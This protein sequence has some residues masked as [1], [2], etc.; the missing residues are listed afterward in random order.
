MGR[1]AVLKSNELYDAETGAEVNRSP[2]WWY[3]R[4]T[5][6][7]DELYRKYRWQFEEGSV[8][9]R[10]DPELGSH[11]CYLSTK[12]KRLHNEAR[13][14]LK[15]WTE[16]VQPMV[17]FYN[18]NPNNDPFFMPINALEMPDTVYAELIYMI[19]TNEIYDALTKPATEIV[20]RAWEIELIHRRVM[21]HVG[22]NWLK[23]DDYL[24]HIADLKAKRAAQ[25][26][27]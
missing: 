3:D 27:V 2:A 9:V 26:G 18:T 12:A 20:V 15:E 4:A 21:P 11:L 8:V 24:K 6:M 25:T 1:K 22:I 5:I 23:P 19:G 14:S 17:N 16:A 13:K 7:T 10:K